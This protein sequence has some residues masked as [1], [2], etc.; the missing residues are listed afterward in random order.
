MLKSLIVWS[1]ENSGFVSVLIFALTLF[2]G[3]ISG[4][5]GALRKKPKFK[6]QVIPGPTLCTTFFTGQK[7]EGHDIHRTAISV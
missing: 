7:H 6:L 5:F 4:I 1:N 2:L 3:W